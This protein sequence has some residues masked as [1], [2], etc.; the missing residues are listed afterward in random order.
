LRF[1]EVT[2][3]EIILIDRSDQPACGAGEPIIGTIGGAIDNAIF[4]ATG[5]R[6]RSLPMTAELVM[7]TPVI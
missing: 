5:K 3:I 1:N 2:K 4:A 6:I 7:A